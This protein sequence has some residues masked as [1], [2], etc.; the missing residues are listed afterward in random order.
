MT[1]S[2]E[3]QYGSSDYGLAGIWRDLDGVAYL[4]PAGVAR[5]T[6]TESFRTVLASP[7][8]AALSLISI[9]AALFL[10]GFFLLVFQNTSQ[11]LQQ[12]SSDVTISM[13]LSETLSEAEQDELFDTLVALEEVKEVQLWNKEKALKEFQNAFAGFDGLVEGLEED[14]PLPASFELQFNP[15]V[16]HERYK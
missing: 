9:S 3:S 7:V 5:Q 2:D 16:S 14:N 11:L 12:S 13:Y 10:L 4:T 1:A 6:I 8:T 15:V